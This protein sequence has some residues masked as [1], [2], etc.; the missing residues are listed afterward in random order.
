MPASDDDRRAPTPSAIDARTVDA[1]TDA[2][3]AGDV[4]AIRAVFAAVEATGPEVIWRPEPRHLVHRPL[5]FLREHWLE[6]AADR[7][8]PLAHEIDAVNLR[9][10]LGFII[11]VDVVEGGRDFRYRLFGSALAAASGFD[12]TGRLLS[13][14]RASPHIPAFYLAAYRAVLRRREP[15]FTEHGPSHVVRT[16]AWHRLVLPL[17]DESGAISRLLVGNIPLSRSGTPLIGRY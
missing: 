12:M 16:K 6:L 8:M 5:R 13:D 9:P 14:H 7:E 3:A 11:L 2:V 1:W 10:A 15:L 4:R 17:A